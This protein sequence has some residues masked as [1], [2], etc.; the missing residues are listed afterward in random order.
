ML[1]FSHDP[2]LLEKFSAVVLGLLVLKL[3]GF[4]GQGQVYLV[5]DLD[6]KV[7]S[8]VKLMDP[9]LA[10]TQPDLVEAFK[11]EGRLLGRLGEHSKSANIVELKFMDETLDGIPVLVM[12]YLRGKTLRELLNELPGGKLS[13]YWV[14]EIGKQVAEG[15]YYA[16]E[17]GVFHLDL[18]LENIFIVSNSN[19]SWGVKILDFGGNR[20]LDDIAK[21]EGQGLF[22]TP[23]SSAP[24]QILGKRVGK[25]TDIFSLG[26][27]LYQGASGNKPFRVGSTLEDQFS[28]LDC[29]PDPISMYGDFPPEL[30]DLFMRT[31]DPDEEKRQQSMMDIITGL[32]VIQV[33]YCDILEKPKPPIPTEE[34]VVM[35]A[36]GAEIIT[37]KSLQPPST[38]IHI[39]P[40]APAPAIDNVHEIPTQPARAKLQKT[41]PA[42]DP[43]T[44][45]APRSPSV[46][47]E[48]QRTREEFEDQRRD[49]YPDPIRIHPHDIEDPSPPVPS[50][51][52]SNDEL[53]RAVSAYMANHPEEEIHHALP[54]PPASVSRIIATP[55]VNVGDPS[56]VPTANPPVPSGDP[57]PRGKGGTLKLQ[58]VPTEQTPIQR[59]KGW[60]LKM[61]NPGPPP[62]PPPEWN[63]PPEPASRGKGWIPI[64]NSVLVNKSPEAWAQMA[65]AQPKSET[66]QIQDRPSP[67]SLRQPAQKPRSADRPTTSSP[68]SRQPTPPRQDP[69]PTPPAPAQQP[70]T[71]R[72]PQVPTFEF[73]RLVWRQCTLSTCIDVI[74]LYA[75]LLLP[76]RRLRNAYL[77][78]MNL[79]IS[80]PPRWNSLSAILVGTFLLLT[81]SLGVFLGLSA[82]PARA[83]VAPPHPIPSITGT[84]TSPPPPPPPPQ[85]AVPATSA[86]AAP[87][88]GIPTK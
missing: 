45:E 19:G 88:A 69:Q 86:F 37:R 87:A 61:D 43:S 31:M 30:N 39:Q 14:I 6:S 8:A 20:L 74:F 4:G 12:E 1:A 63:Q 73:L 10:R 77:R 38:Q 29:P 17:R 36:E 62:P 59:G 41:V 18:K 83:S 52:L 82:S 25:T 7:R 56:N 24:E 28:R 9:V 35:S 46:Q 48:I 13:L 65:S 2:C 15:L 22:V 75:Y 21:G 72:L 26:Y 23:V 34:R 16:H 40:T 78:A 85:S 51:A 11:S 66:R 58:P 84:A 55:I 76:T 54:A 50:D 68:S 32:K 49:T 5:R 64:G 70:G 3:L 44:Q 81:I 60:T 27:V 79:Y 47:A 71:L 42:S 80:R 53:E 57:I 33:K 67:Q